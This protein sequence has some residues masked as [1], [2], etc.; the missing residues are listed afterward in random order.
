MKRNYYS[1][2]FDFHKFSFE[3]I[4][5]EGEDPFMTPS[6]DENSGYQGSEYQGDLG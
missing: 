3:R 6:G 5:E 4:L 2:E 1:P